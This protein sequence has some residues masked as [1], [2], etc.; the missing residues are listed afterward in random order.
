MFT[1]TVH[2]Y[3]TSKT[4]SVK[5]SH[6]R[7]LIDHLEASVARAHMTIE[8]DHDGN[9]GTVVRRGK[10]VGYWDIDEALEV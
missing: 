9:G 4:V 8:F 2:R 5:A 1:L 10:S 3:G 6:R 7:A